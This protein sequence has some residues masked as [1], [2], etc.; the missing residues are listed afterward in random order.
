MMS[1]ARNFVENRENTEQRH[2]GHEGEAQGLQ[3]EPSVLEKFSF[4]KFSIPRIPTSSRCCATVAAHSCSALGSRAMRNFHAPVRNFSAPPRT[5]HA[6][7]LSLLPAFDYEGAIHRTTGTVENYGRFRSR[8]EFAGTKDVTVVLF[9]WAGS[10]DSHVAKYA[11]MYERAGFGF[12]P[13]FKF[14]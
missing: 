6:A 13:F 9:G 12:P 11:A 14:K 7:S 8:P 1:N 10:R 4:H 5:L 2:I 3:A